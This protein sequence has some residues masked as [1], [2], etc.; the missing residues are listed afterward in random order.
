MSAT[1][2]SSIWLKG[3][4]DQAI[5]R[6]R[7]CCQHVQAGGFS[8]SS[9]FFFFSC[10]QNFA[11]GQL[12]LEQT[13]YVRFAIIRTVFAS[14]GA[15]CTLGRNSFAE[16]DDILKFSAKWEGIRHFKMADVYV[17]LLLLVCWHRFALYF[18]VKLQ[19]TSVY[20][21]IV[22][23]MYRLPIGRTVT[24][25]YHEVRQYFIC[26]IDA[27]KKWPHVLNR[28]LR[29]AEN[30]LLVVRIAFRKCISVMS[31]T[32]RSSIWLKG[33]VDQAILR[34]RH[35]CQHVQAG[36]FSSSSFFF[37]FSC[38]QN[39][40]HG[41]LSLEQTYYV[42]FAIIRTVF[43]SGGAFCTLGRNSFAEKDDILKFSAK[44]EGI[45]HF[46][47]ADVYVPLLLLVCWHRFALYF[48]VKLQKT[49]VYKDIVSYM[50]VT[51][52]KNSD[53]N[54]QEFVHLHDDLYSLLLKAGSLCH[55]F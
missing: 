52:R 47:M 28:I 45:R 49:S 23:Y 10:H 8:S 27:E 18:G 43:A 50:Q 1:K 25:T 17:P 35:C 30:K 55:K 39:F 21:D 19:K 14:G 33:F 13:Y 24:L 31:A 36:G 32:K 6:N 26:R 37:F 7:H 48:G 42:R 4:V 16:K 51:N 20:K 41:Q 22:S 54:L 2:R 38:H 12:S 29:L 44:W 53:I 34:N 15:F 5:L 46:K 3:F 9:F 11:H 40:A